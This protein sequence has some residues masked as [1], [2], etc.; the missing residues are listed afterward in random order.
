MKKKKSNISKYYHISILSL[1]KLLFIQ[2]KY[3]VSFSLVQPTIIKGEN[4][5]LTAVQR[6]II[7]TMRISHRRSLLKRMNVHRVL[8]QSTFMES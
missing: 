4:A 8:Y 2:S 1:S 3:C 7:N 5:D 6:A